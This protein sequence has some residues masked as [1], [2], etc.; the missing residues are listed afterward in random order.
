MRVAE[1]TRRRSFGIMVICDFYEESEGDFVR[2]KMRIHL[3]T[4]KTPSL[5]STR[6]SSLFCS[7]MAH[8]GFCAG[9]QPDLLSTEVRPSNILQLKSKICTQL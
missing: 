5:T 4:H 2:E 1:S 8:S 3:K 7:P 6:C 9:R